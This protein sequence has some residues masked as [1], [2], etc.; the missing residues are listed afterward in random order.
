MSRAAT[1][2]S[3]PGRSLVSSRRRWL[4]VLLAAGAGTVPDG[5]KHAQWRPGTIER[6]PQGNLARGRDVEQAGDHNDEDGQDEHRPVL[7]SPG[8]AAALI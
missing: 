2:A 8:A 5:A 7:L 1:T 6:T 4:G 3:F